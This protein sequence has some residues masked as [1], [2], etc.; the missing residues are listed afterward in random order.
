MRPAEGESGTDEESV[1]GAEEDDWPFR[2]RP[3]ISL[4]PRQSVVK[5]LADLTLEACACVAEDSDPAVTTGDWEI[6]S[7]DQTRRVGLVPA[8]WPSS[9]GRTGSSRP[10]IPRSD[11]H[12]V[13][14]SDEADRRASDLKPGD[15]LLA[16]IVAGKRVSNVVRFRIGSG[17]DSKGG[18]LLEIEAVE[19]PPDVALPLLAIRARRPTEADPAPRYSDVAYPK[20]IV[21]GQ[22]RRWEGFFW[23]GGDYPLH[24]GEEIAYLLDLTTNLHPPVEADRIHRVTA[25]VGSLRSPTIRLEVNR[26]NEKAWDEAT[27]RLPQPQVSLRGR[28]TA[29]DG[30]PGAEYDV[31]IRDEALP[32]DVDGRIQ[33]RADHQGRYVFHDLPV[34]MYTVRA[35]LRRSAEPSL[36]V[37][38]VAVASGRTREQ[39]LDLTSRVQIG[40]RVVD[41]HGKPIAGRK[42]SSTWESQDGRQE[43]SA[44]AVTDAEGKYQIG[45]PLPIASYVR[46]SGPGERPSAYHDVHA[47]SDK[48]DFVVKQGG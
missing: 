38:G 3:W 39:D 17:D 14:P 20:L 45:S 6:R 32:G 37:K 44:S 27:T 48:V 7:A 8:D 24:V 40:G 42:V 47:P 23:M 36:E 21:D 19:A 10:A 41:Q 26:Q 16:W 9:P 2:A 12:M 29:P 11:T 5:S 25:I 46:P 34:G 18:P 43:F 1:A 35:D 28:V 33:A 4:L 13:R 30:R 22:A 15:Y 31:Y